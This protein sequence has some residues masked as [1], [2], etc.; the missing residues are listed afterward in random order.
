MLHNLIKVRRAKIWGPPEDMQAGAG[1]QGR[2]RPPS[3]DEVALV[4]QLKVGQCSDP[5]LQVQAALCYSLLSWPAATVHGLAAGMQCHRC[6][7]KQP[8]LCPW[9][10]AGAVRCWQAAGCRRLP[11]QQQRFSRCLSRSKK[12]EG[13]AGSY[14]C[15]ARRAAC[16]LSDLPCLCKSPCPHAVASESDQVPLGR[17]LLLQPANVMT[18]C[19][20]LHLRGQPTAADSRPA[21]ARME[22]QQDREG[23]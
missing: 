1:Q 5:V 22:Q 20:Q 6:P 14:G 4:K 7:M 9:S 18:H 10:S 19:R 16:W 11:P 8:H 3:K 2:G 17:V 15:A 12:H 13:K 21:Q 23:T